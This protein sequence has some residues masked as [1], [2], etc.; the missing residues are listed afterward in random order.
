MS[1]SFTR[2]TVGQG[3]AL[4]DVFSD[5]RGDS[6]SGLYS[7]IHSLRGGGA[8]AVIVPELAHLQHV[9]RLA[10]ADMSTAA[11]FL[12]ARLIVGGICAEP[13]QGGVLVREAVGSA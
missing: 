7:M 10:D 13:W 2:L 12:G 3:Y 5:V 4:V 1:T 11:R 8:V 9:E 6:E